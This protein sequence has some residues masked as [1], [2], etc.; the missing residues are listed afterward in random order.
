MNYRLT[1]QDYKD[2]LN[3]KSRDPVSWR[4]AEARYFESKG[5]L[6][7]LSPRDDGEVDG[8]IDSHPNVTLIHAGMIMGVPNIDDR[9]ATF[10]TLYPEYANATDN[11]ISQM[12]AVVVKS[13]EEDARK[14][15]EDERELDRRANLALAAKIRRWQAEGAS[16]RDIVYRLMNP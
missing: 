14:N 8:F 2:L 15:L 4:A 9:F 3:K 5:E 1:I 11:R 12:N 13:I 10:R 16:N 7:H 6:Q